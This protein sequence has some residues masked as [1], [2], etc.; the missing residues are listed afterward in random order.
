MQ[1]ILLKGFQLI[2][3]TIFILISSEENVYRKILKYDQISLPKYLMFSSLT[4]S[5]R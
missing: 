2:V 5:L 3:V 1:L 4:V